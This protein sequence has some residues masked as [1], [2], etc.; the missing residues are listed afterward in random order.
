MIRG[1][2]YW[3]IGPIITFF[4]FITAVVVYHL[5][6]KNTNF[7]HVISRIWSKI[8]LNFL[9][10]VKLKIK[11]LDKIDPNQKYIIVSNHRS[12]IDIFVASASI[13][14]QF[15][16]LAKESLFKLPLI[17]YGMKICGYI[18]VTR[19]KAFSAVKSLNSVKEVLEDGKS[20]WIFPEGTRTKKKELGRFKRGAFIMAK[21]TGVPIL[22]VV[23]VNTDRLFQSPIKISPVEIYV[24]ILEPVIYS[25]YLKKYEDEKVAI[26][27]LVDDIREKIQKVYNY[28]E[29][30]PSK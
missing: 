27:K 10:G 8:I 16:W 17:G 11:G 6:G 24:E 9:C 13:P 4:L 20:V 15:R 5:N 21:E 1:I 29:F 2:L 30:K 18:P 14:L 7:P 26:N 22:P 23:M 3:V 28:Y 25:D 19:E 12:N